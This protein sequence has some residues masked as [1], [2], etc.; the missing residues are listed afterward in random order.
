MWSKVVSGQT[1]EAAENL[2]PVLVRNAIKPTLIRNLRT[3]K[4]LSGEETEASRAPGVRAVCVRSRSEYLLI[5]DG[6]EK[7]LLLPLLLL[8]LK[9]LL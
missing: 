9:T 7:P 4:S 3:T 2:T 1:F 6:S 8:L 5:A